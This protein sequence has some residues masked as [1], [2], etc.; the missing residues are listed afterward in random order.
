METRSITAGKKYAR[1]KP[2]PML[3]LVSLIIFG[4]TLE[5]SAASIKLAWDPSSEPLVTG[6]RLYY[7]K[8]SGVY[9]NVADAG[10]RTDFTATGLD[11]GATY[12]FAAT[13]YTGAGDESVMSNETS[14]TIPGSS[15]TPAPTPPGDSSGGG[16]GSGGGCFIAT[17]A[18][19]SGLA[20]EVAVLR[21]FRDRYLMTNRSWAGFC[22]L[23]LC[24]LAA[25][26]GLH[27]R[28]RISEDHCAPGIDP[29]CLR[30][31]IPGSGAGSRSAA[32]GGH[33]RQE[34]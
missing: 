33:R 8:S 12:Y 17:A 7:G 19:G 14:Y 13:A 21:D 4:S 34:S 3:L 30:R 29:H 6:Y 18:Y 25:R 11:A 24:R 31:E 26:G 22:R 23:V 28:A 27:R 9:T 32:P 1:R 15:P 2:F 20:P 5:V 10:N 16:G